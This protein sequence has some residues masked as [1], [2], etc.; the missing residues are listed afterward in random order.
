MQA[1][2]DRGP[3]GIPRGSSLASQSCNDGSLEAQLS[4]R[5]ADRPHTQTCLGCAHL[6][7]MFQECHRLAGAFAAYTASYCATGSAQGPRLKVRRSPPPPHARALVRSPHN[8]GSQHSAHRTPCRAPD[9]THAERQQPDGN[10]LQVDKQITLITTIKRHRVAAGRVRH[11]PGPL[12]TAGVEVRSSSRTLT[13][14]RNPDQHP[15]THTHLRR[16][17]FPADP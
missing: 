16:A 4:D 1:R 17:L 7:A 13:S 9:H 12:K 6:L 15:V 8:L 14:T 2:L 5:P 3:H 11:R 10:T